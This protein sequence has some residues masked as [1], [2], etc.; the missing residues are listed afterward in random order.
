MEPLQALDEPKLKGFLAEKGVSKVLFIDDG[1]EPLEGVEPMDEEQKDLWAEIEA[2]GVALDAAGF[3]GIHVPQD[4]TAE[5]IARLRQ[6]P[7]GDALG[8]LVNKSGYVTTHLSKT[9]T[10]RRASD[11]LKDLGLAVIECG[12]DDWQDALAGASI[13]FLDWRLGPDED[14]DAAQTAMEVAAKIHQAGSEAR[15]MIVLMS[16]DMS[17][18]ERA[19]EFSQ[20]SG[21]ISGLFDAMPKAW[22]SNPA[23]VDLQMAVLCEHLEKGHVVQKFVDEVDRCTKVA[24]HDFLRKIRE[25]TLSDYA[26]LQHFALKR[27]GHPLG[28]Y[29]TELLAGVWMDALFRGALR[30]NLEALDAED[31]ESMPTLVQPSGAVND[32]YNAAMFDT[33]VGNFKGHPHAVAS[34]DG[35]PARLAITLGDIIVGQEDAAPLKIY[36]VINPQCDLAESPRHRRHIDDNLSILLVPGELHPVDTWERNERREMADTPYFA[37]DGIKGRIQWNGKKQIS[38]RYADFSDWLNNMHARREARMRSTFALA[39]QT[40][41]RSELTRVGLPA[42]PPMYESIDV[43]LRE[44]DRGQ[45]KR[46]SRKVRLGQLVMARESESDHLI[47]PHSIVNDIFD[48]VEKGAAAL[49]GSRVNR[50]A[51]S[52]EAIKK[53]V[54]DPAELLP[55]AKPFRVPE[56]GAKFL[57]NAVFVCR[58]SQTPPETFDRR[59]MVC[60]ILPD[61]KKSSS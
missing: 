10:I 6:R 40:A 33:Y 58:K 44:A 53:A 50:D 20:K 9:Q 5:T 24:A 36:V 29:L 27:E 3:E 31:F 49:A 17:V 8:Q 38:V 11:Y 39:L 14:T 43:E 54:S 61:K 16:S 26:N 7:E 45:W 51:L 28:D 35:M 25:L 59:Y 37:V 32:L 12:R 34:D 46:E 1:F 47:L 13:V 18:K 60:L 52:A 48:I 2:D 30:E 42:A 21:I 15:P 22:L 19:R 55:L 23:K 4:L 41:V 56:S 57:G